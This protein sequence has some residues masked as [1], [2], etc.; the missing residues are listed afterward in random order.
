MAKTRATAHYSK[1]ASYYDEIYATIV[2]YEKQTRFL[3][4]II[5]KHLGRKPR[6]VLDI[7]SGTGNY[8]F[9]FAKHGYKTTGIDASGEMLRV[10]RAKAGQSNN[11]RFYK[12]DMRKIRLDQRYDVA[13]VLFGGFGYL[14]KEEDVGLFF[15]S[16]SIHLNRRGLLMFEFWQNSAILPGATGKSGMKSWDLAET[17]DRLIVRLNLSRYDPHTN[18]LDVK[19]DFYI[20]DR[21]RKELVDEFSEIHLVRTYSISQMRALLERYSLKALGFYDGDLVR[22]EKGEVAPAS[23]STFRVMAVARPV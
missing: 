13:T 15:G 16:A 1:M 23:F 8:T 19:F 18:V 20:L 5:Q 4:K 14:E 7:A 11:P 9:V 22:A 6:S 10:A 2:D 17:G 21:K 3:E 12:M